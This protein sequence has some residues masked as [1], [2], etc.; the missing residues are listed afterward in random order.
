MRAIVRHTTHYH[1]TAMSKMIKGLSLKRYWNL[2]DSDGIIRDSLHHQCT[3][4]M[5]LQT[6][7]VATS[8]SIAKN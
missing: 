1:P 6:K 5:N 8:S 3:L 4:K 2:W 7:K